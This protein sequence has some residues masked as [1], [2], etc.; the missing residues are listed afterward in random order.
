MADIEKV[1]KWGAD[2]LTGILAIV[3]GL[4]LLGITYKIIINLILFSVGLALIYF[5]LTKLKI[6]VV[7]AFMDKI[8]AKIKKF[9]S[10]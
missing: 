7:T 8:F 10:V 1:K 3:A 9:L 5:G 4:I 6:T 2:N